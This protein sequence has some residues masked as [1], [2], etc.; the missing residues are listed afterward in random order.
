MV[1]YVRHGIRPG[2]GCQHIVVVNVGG[3]ATVPSALPDLPPNAKYLFHANYGYDW[4]TF[5]W[6]LRTEN[7]RVEDYMYYVF[8][9][10][11]VRGPIVPPYLQGKVHFTKL[12]T[13]K[14]SDEVKLVGPTINCESVTLASGRTRSNPHVQSFAVATDQ[15]GMKILIDDGN[16]FGCYTDFTE[17]MYYSEVGLSAVIMKAG[18]NV[19]S[20][21]LRYQGVD[22]RDESNWNCGD[23]ENPFNLAR[24]DEHGLNPMEL[25]FVKYSL[26]SAA[27]NTPCMQAARLQSRWLDAY[28][29]G[30][31]DLVSFSKDIK[32]HLW[33]RRYPKVLARIAHGPE[34]WDC[35]FYLTKNEDLSGMGCHEAFSHFATYGQFESRPHRFTCEDNAAESILP[36]THASLKP[37]PII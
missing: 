6:V 14:L 7:I 23:N 18:Y 5:G 37:W 4:G 31:P 26:W 20:F 3:D 11:S 33:E 35:D 15:V 27:A 25:I 29:E 17:T 9:N 36:L 32:D 16:V 30:L 10:S 28:R 22:W 24:D 12:M 2:D 34:C 19:D 8:L 13:S 21:M 1:F